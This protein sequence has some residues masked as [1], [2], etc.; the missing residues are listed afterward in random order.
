MY[1]HVGGSDRG[2]F[3]SDFKLIVFPVRVENKGLVLV[4]ELAASVLAVRDA[5]V[6][7]KRRSDTSWTDFTNQEDIF[8]LRLLH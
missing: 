6:S 5:A 3:S 4:V 2:D 8:R 7:V 1:P